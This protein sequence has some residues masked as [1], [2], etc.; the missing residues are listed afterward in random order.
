[1]PAQTKSERDAQDTWKS[2]LV[3]EA[4]HQPQYARGLP[5][6]APAEC[7]A[8]HH[9]LLDLVRRVEQVVALESEAPAQRAEL[10]LLV[11]PCVQ[12]ERVREARP[13]VR[14]RANGLRSLRK[15]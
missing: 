13:S 3:R 4:K 5:R 1:M 8:G 2:P 12:S 15:I 9:V 7:G 6:C 11:D 10:D 14:V